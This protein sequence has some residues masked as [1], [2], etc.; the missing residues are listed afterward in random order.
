MFTVAQSDFAVFEINCSNILKDKSAV[1][2]NV[3]NTQ[4]VA[5]LFSM[6]FGQIIDPLI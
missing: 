1:K 5:F 6:A 3:R 2:K 4:F